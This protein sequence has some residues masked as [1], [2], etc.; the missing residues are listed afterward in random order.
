MNVSHITSNC[1]ASLGIVVYAFVDSQGFMDMHT[2]K[3]SMTDQNC[4]WMDF[5]LD[6]QTKKTF[7][8]KE[9]III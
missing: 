8:G 7:P 5:F 4:N 6:F 3:I 2:L 1:L 9:K